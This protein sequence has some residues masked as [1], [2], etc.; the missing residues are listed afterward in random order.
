MG[1]TLGIR[2]WTNHGIFWVHAQA[3]C[4][5][6]MFWTASSG[7]HGQHYKKRA[8]RDPFL[9]LPQ[10]QISPE[11]C[12]KHMQ[13]LQTAQA[14]FFLNAG[15]LGDVA[16]TQFAMARHLVTHCGFMHVST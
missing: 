10:I 12:C 1:Y 16:H 15:V 9:I 4:D 8:V 2:G 14:C 7:T 5:C 6:F 13:N 3:R 11:A